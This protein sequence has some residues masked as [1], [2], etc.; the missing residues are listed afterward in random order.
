MKAEW[1]KSPLERAKR[2]EPLQ[3]AAQRIAELEA[4]VRTLRIERDN[5]RQ[6]RNQMLDVARRMEMQRDQ[7]LEKSHLFDLAC[8][9]ELMVAD[10][11]GFKLLKGKE[12][13]Q[14]CKDH[15]YLNASERYKSALARSMQQSKAEAVNEMLNQQIYNYVIH[16]R[17]Q[18]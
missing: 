17:S 8:H 13:E 4:Q 14:Y 9:L 15:A 3:D 12:L 6:M 16:S 2:K 11:D 1:K 7:A 10:K 5:E 18:S